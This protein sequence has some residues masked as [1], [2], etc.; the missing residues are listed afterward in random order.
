MLEV[1]VV[2]ESE[3]VADTVQGED[4]A[5][6]VAVEGVP[7][8]MAATESESEADAATDEDVPEANVETEEGVQGSGR[9]GS[10]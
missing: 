3:S 2:A 7:E 8:A 1:K 10:V 5:K 6:V 4:K 9:G